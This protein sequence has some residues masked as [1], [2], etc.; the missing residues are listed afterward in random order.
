MDDAR[1][2][3]AVQRVAADAGPAIGSVAVREIRLTE[4]TLTDAGPD[5]ETIDR[6]PL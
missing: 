1:G 4:S 5:Y 3:A 6:Y 2:K